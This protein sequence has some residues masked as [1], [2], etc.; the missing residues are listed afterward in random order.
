MKVPFFTSDNKCYYIT[1]ELI[2]SLIRLT[3]VSVR[4]LGRPTIF[5]GLMRIP[6]FDPTSTRVLLKSFALF[7]FLSVYTNIHV[8]I[9]TA[10]NMSVPK[11]LDQSHWGL[12]EKLDLLRKIFSG[13]RTR[14]S[15]DNGMGAK[16]RPVK[17]FLHKSLLFINKM[18]NNI[19]PFR[20]NI[21][22]FFIICY[23]NSVTKQK[24]KNL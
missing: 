23:Q 11:F 4:S 21:C 19:T 13:S 2:S 24:K 5:G 17:P 9:L 6:I 10:V 3:Y 7:R 1:D 16:E 12:V 20:E 18:Q 8:S 22:R 14:P 15:R